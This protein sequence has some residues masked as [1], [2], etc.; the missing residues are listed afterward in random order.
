MTT[1][2]HQINA[3]RGVLNPL[4]T[5]HRGDVMVLIRN[6]FKQAAGKMEEVKF[7]SAE[8][9][10]R[11]K[12]FGTGQS[13]EISSTINA[14]VAVLRLALPLILIA[15]AVLLLWALGKV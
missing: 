8:E 14:V 12:V 13:A 3:V 1:D 5:E 10:F 15:S 6:L 9:R 4:G 11:I 7:S 2:T